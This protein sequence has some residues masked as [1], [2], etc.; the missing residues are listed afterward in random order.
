MTK[1]CPLIQ[2]WPKTNISLQNVEFMEDKQTT[3]NL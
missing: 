1:Y 2:V 3:Y